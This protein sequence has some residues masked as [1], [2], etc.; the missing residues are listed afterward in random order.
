MQRRLGRPALHRFGGRRHHQQS[1]G[2]RKNSEL[3][4][5]A[6]R[7]ERR[8]AHQPTVTIAR[9][10]LSVDEQTVAWADGKHRVPASTH[11]AAHRDDHCWTSD[12]DGAGPVR[13]KPAFV[14]AAG[15]TSWHVD[16]DG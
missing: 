16:V 14:E 4:D 7:V 9:L 11:R 15:L 2:K 1:G 13:R 5:C 3:A 10:P 12:P 6:A 8:L